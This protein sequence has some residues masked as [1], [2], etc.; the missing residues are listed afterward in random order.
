MP[1]SASPPTSKGCSPHE[2]FFLHLG[3]RRCAVFGDPNEYRLQYFFFFHVYVRVIGWCPVMTA[4]PSRGLLRVYLLR[5]EEDCHVGGLVDVEISH[6]AYHGGWEIS[7][8][9]PTGHR[10]WVIVYWSAKRGATF[11]L[12]TNG[13]YARP[14]TRVDTEVRGDIA[15]AR[16][17]L[18]LLLANRP[19]PGPLRRLWHADLYWYLQERSEADPDAPPTA[20]GQWIG[21]CCCRRGSE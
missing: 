5:L 6:H 11:W 3:P 19:R 16:R 15:L 2:K 9:L 10:V 7:G 18:G 12:G 8:R 4:Y 17:Y 21:W 14:G 1:S 13:Q 20:R